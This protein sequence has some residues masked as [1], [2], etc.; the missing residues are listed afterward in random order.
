MIY[1]VLDHIGGADVIG[2]D[3]QGKKNIDINF[4]EYRF[5]R[6]FH[7]WKLESERPSVANGKE[8]SGWSGQSGVVEW[9]D[10]DDWRPMEYLT[11]F[12]LC[13][14]ERREKSSLAL[15]DLWCWIKRFRPRLNGRMNLFSGD[16][17]DG[18]QFYPKRT[19]GVEVRQCRL[20]PKLVR[21][22]IF[23]IFR[24]SSISDEDIEETYSK[25][26]P[27]SRAYCWS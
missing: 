8:F 23:W 16:V 21:Q 17:C 19:S 18:D 3:I 22:K 4:P 1:S 2:S 11:Q 14:F 12:L 20:E 7:C 15:I 25:K 10:T 9:S 13:F 27:H 5:L 24:W 6:V 26:V